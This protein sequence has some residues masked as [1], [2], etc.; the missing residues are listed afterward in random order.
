MN[1]SWC[2][3]I[4]FDKI[5]QPLSSTASDAGFKVNYFAS[6]PQ[7]THVLISYTKIGHLKLYIWKFMLAKSTLIF[8]FLLF[9]VLKYMWRMLPIPNPCQ[10][11]WKNAKRE[12]KHF[13]GFYSF[14]EGVA[15]QNECNGFISEASWQFD[16]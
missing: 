15:A 9:Q 6:C 14:Q 12:H 4:D 1:W 3:M 8:H 10:K 2:L 7:L 11:F 16:W 5:D 13:F